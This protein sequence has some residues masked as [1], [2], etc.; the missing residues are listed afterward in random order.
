MGILQ[1]QPTSY[2]AVLKPTWAMNWR[3]S[4][5][6]LAASG[7]G[8]GLAASPWQWGRPQAVTVCANRRRQHLACCPDLLTVKGIWLLLY[9]WFPEADTTKIRTVPKLG[10]ELFPRLHCSFKRWHLER[11]GHFHPCLWERKH[12]ALTC[13]DADVSASS[14]ETR[15][16]WE[17][18]VQGWE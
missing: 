17:L 5:G 14:S 15:C 4:R 10:K 6:D 8:L 2:V 7:V 1:E 11:Q 16:E 13:V 9:F 12:V 3:C 18:G